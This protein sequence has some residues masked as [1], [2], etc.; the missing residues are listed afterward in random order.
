MK[1]NKYI[2]AYKGIKAP[3]TLR[4]RVKASAAHD[5]QTRRRRMLSRLLPAAAMF[6]LVTAIVIAWRAGA[7]DT[8]A[9]I[10]YNGQS[11]DSSVL[12]SV[13]NTFSTTLLV[14]GIQTPGGIKLE[15]HITEATTVTVT[16]GIVTL[17]DENGTPTDTGEL[18]RISGGPDLYT[19]YWKADFYMANEEDPFLLT[20]EDSHGSVTYNLTGSDGDLTLQKTI[21]N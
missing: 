15:V 21:Q 12:I 5:S 14:P 10:I 16:N 6:V 4:D 2:D 18:V 9:Y 17:V 20:L 3:E 19:I 8:A 1:F 13:S 11:V 7:G